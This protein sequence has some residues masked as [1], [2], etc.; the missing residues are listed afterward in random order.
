MTWHN[1]LECRQAGRQKTCPVW[2]CDLFCFTSTPR[3]P[4]SSSKTPL[5]DQ[6]DRKAYLVWSCVAFVSASTLLRP[7][8]SSQLSQLD[9]ESIQVCVQADRRHTQLGDS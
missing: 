6:A 7:S 8:G 3:K 9:Q 2:M 1:T 4:L 5:L